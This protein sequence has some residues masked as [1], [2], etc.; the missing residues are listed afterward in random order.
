MDEQHLIREAERIHR[1]TLVLDAHFDLAM[2]LLDRTER[3]EKDVFR[4]VF[5]P[6][7]REGGVDCVVSS[8]F[9][10]RGHLPE[11]ALRRGLDQVE[12]LR[13]EIEQW[14]ERL[15]LCTT[16]EDIRNASASDRLAIML[17]F[18]GAEPMGNDIRLLSVFHRLGVRGLGLVWSRRNYLADGCPFTTVEAG[19]PGGLTDLGVKAVR[20]AERLGMWIDVSHLNDEGFY[21]VMEISKKPVIASHSNCRKLVPSPRNLT[22]DQIRTLA[23]KGGVMGMNGCSI[24][25]GNG[26]GP[27][28]ARDLA[29]H[30][31]HVAKVAGIEHVGLGLDFCDGFPAPPGESDLL[32]SRDV[33]AGHGRIVE[34][35]AELLERGYS[36]NHIGLALGGNFMRVLGE[37]LVP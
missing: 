34:L 4:T 2:D 10:S 1:E 13:Q 7:F 32:P 9:V 36:K 23:R 17:S 16:V 30:V 25:V 3:G 5:D 33:I 35:T 24:F 31:D 37:V 11:Q 12:C 19:R 26:P 29:D 8:I 27:F 28:S 20:E 14:P 15:A 18:E 6:P 22:D 21:D